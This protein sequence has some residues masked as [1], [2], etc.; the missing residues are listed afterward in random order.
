MATRAVV[1]VSFLFMGP[2]GTQGAG[3]WD[4]TYP[5]RTV[6]HIRTHT[7]TYWAPMG[8]LAAHGPHFQFFRFLP[9]GPPRIFRKVSVVMPEEQSL[10]IL[11]KRHGH[12]GTDEIAKAN[13]AAQ[14]LSRAAALLPLSRTRNMEVNKVPSIGA[15]AGC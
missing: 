10:P 6:F 2:D 8:P 13:S 12:I 3:V 14:L 9:P 4:G 1:V 11:Q 15:S 7:D 5:N